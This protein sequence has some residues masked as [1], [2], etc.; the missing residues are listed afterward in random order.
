M[1]KI[2][3]ILALATCSMLAHATVIYDESVDGDAPSAG[4]SGLVGANVGTLLL[5]DNTIIGTRANGQFDDY[6]FEVGAAQNLLGI[7]FTSIADIGSGWSA[8][9]YTSA[10]TLLSSFDPGALTGGA[11]TSAF[12]SALPLSAG[13]YRIDHNSGPGTD[14]SYSWVL[15]TRAAQVPEPTTL[16]LVG[17]GLAGLGYRKRR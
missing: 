8:D 9:L 1:K 11:S 10:G 12:G 13:V 4:G 2:I 16:A 15:T 17:L 6:I 5:G 7:S 14:V 3:A